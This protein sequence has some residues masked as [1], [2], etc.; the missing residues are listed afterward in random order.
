MTAFEKSNYLTF[1]FLTFY[2]CL[3]FVR[4]FQ[5]SVN[6]INNIWLSL[7]QFVNNRISVFLNVLFALLP[8]KHS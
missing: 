4:E 3:F 5:F 8:R 7:L 2:F 1:Y 6:S